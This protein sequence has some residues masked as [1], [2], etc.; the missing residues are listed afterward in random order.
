MAVILLQQHCHRFDFVGLVCTV[1]APFA[2]RKF[3]DRLFDQVGSAAD[4]APTGNLSVT[5]LSLPAHS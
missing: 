3:A 5:S 4:C 1:M 2:Q